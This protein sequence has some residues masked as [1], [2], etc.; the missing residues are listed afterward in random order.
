LQQYG[1]SGIIN[2]VEDAD[3]ATFAGS[4][5][6]L[7]NSSHGAFL[8]GANGSPSGKRERPSRVA[9]SAAVSPLEAVSRV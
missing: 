6:E 2:F 8:G 4:V 5:C 3:G 1:L 7:V 9:S